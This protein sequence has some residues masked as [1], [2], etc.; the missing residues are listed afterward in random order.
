MIFLYAVAVLFV[1]KPDIV[2]DNIL[3]VPMDIYLLFHLCG[4][5]F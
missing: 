5:S 4:S 2:N 1:A 3:L